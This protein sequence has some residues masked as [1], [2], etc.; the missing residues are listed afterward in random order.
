MGWR[1]VWTA[2]PFTITLTEI[3]MSDAPIENA[4]PAPNPAPE[5]P[6]PDATP[7]PEAGKDPVDNPTP[8]GENVDPKPAAADP[9]AAAFV[10]PDEYKD[11]PWAAKVKSTEDLY[12][13]IDNLTTLAGKKNAYPAAD[14]TPEQ[15]NE[16]Y[17][18]LRPE[19]AEVYDFGKDHPNPEVAKQFGEMLFKSNI[20]QHQAKQLITDYQAFEKATM[21]KATSADGFKEVMTKQF[22]EKYDA[23]VATISKSL[24]QYASKEDQAVINAMPNEYIGSVYKLMDSI[25][26]AHGATQGGADLHN[27]KA[28]VPSGGV[29]IE[30]QRSEIR[31]K[32]TAL[33]NGPHTAKQKQDLVD[34]LDATYRNTK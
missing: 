19:S 24:E 23:T 6:T 20:S 32:I 28:G 3:I 8:G 26:K 15:L 27:E 10:L 34:A 9:K 29:P 5:N 2:S 12:K 1:C 30:T 22:G 16:Y 31:S 4:T 11:K 7:S 25:L 18:G 13:Q 33:E 14:A 17:A 21:E